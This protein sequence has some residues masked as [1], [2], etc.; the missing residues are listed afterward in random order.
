MLSEES[1][2]VTLF[3][4][5]TSKTNH[6]THFYVKA[7]RVEIWLQIIHLSWFFFTY[8]ISVLNMFFQII[9]RMFEFGILLFATEINMKT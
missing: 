9:F 7:Q 4:N 5:C 2:C 1:H 6:I 3:L 8:C